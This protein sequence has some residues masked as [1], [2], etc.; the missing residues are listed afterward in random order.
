M[1]RLLLSGLLAV[2]LVQAAQAALKV[3]TETAGESS[4]QYFGNGELV[5]VQGGQPQFGIDRAGNCW[6]IQAGQLVSDP[7][8]GMF[9]AIRGVRDQAM[10]GMDARQRAMM[11]QMMAAPRPVT[12]PPVRPT[13]SRTIAGYPT[14]CHAVGSDREVCVSARLMDEVTRELGNGRFIDMAR[15]L[16]QSMRGAAG[17][18][19]DAG[20]VDALFAKGYPMSDMRTV[21]VSAIPGLDPAMLNFL[22]EA[23][24]AQVM[25][26]LGPAGASRQQGHQV[27]AVERGVK[28]PAVDL[29]RYQRIGF[30]EFMQQSMGRMGGMPLPR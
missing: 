10:A 3:T 23:Q 1:N 21:A 2:S 9:E 27:V 20:A 5:L 18:A 28:M 12:A 13:G 11:Q 4:S 8:E 7:C 26:Q 17:A 16:G 24:R 30:A 25:K 15:Q 19:Q 6:F 29:S 22:P 14:E